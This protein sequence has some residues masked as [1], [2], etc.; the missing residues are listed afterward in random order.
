MSR[1]EVFE[2]LDDFRKIEIP[3]VEGE[4]C[5]GVI[6]VCGFDADCARNVQEGR[7]DVV[8]GVCPGLEDEAWLQEGHVWL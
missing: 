8:Y 7:P 4:R 2:P 3:H 5:A 6:D 1:R